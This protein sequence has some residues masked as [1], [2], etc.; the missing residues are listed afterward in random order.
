M[1]LVTFYAELFVLA[2]GPIPACRI[3]VDVIWSVYD[4]TI[5]D[6]ELNLLKHASMHDFLYMPHV[7]SHVPIVILVI[8]QQLTLLVQVGRVCDSIVFHMRSA[9]PFCNGEYG[10]VVCM[11][12]PLV[13]HQS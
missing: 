4:H 1:I 10:A 5:F 7:L 9:T 6:T 2:K 13:R 11:S 12:M 3:L 8:A